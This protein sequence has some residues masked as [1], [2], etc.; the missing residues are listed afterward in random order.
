MRIRKRL[1]FLSVAICYCA[2]PISARTVPTADRD[3]DRFCF[4][5]S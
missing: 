4:L 1:S 2:F 3:V 5:Q